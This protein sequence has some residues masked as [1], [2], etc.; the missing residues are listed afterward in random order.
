MN[1]EERIKQKEQMIDILNKWSDQIRMNDETVIA[2]NRVIKLQQN[3]IE[4][5]KNK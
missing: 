2:L 1:N 3:E 4:R 5:L